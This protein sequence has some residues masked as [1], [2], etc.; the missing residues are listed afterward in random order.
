MPK[1]KIYTGSWK[2]R[3]YWE[4]KLRPISI[5]LWAPHWRGARLGELAPARDTFKG[6]GTV[7][8]MAKAYQ[9]KVLSKLDPRKVAKSIGH[10][11]VLCCFEE[12]GAMCYRRLVAE[13]LEN[14]LGLEITEVGFPRWCIPNFVDAPED[15]YEVKD[16][17]WQYGCQCGHDT[18]VRLTDKHFWCGG[19]GL[20]TKIVW[21]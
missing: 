13:W 11:G 1:L 2:Q 8:G 21:E 18:P 7:E 17:V 16:S 9:T 12:A 5:C 14:E 3:K 15:K 4:P 10:N 20:K 6:A 19:C